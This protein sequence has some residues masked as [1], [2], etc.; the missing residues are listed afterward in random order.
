MI[1]ELYLKGRLRHGLSQEEAEAI[2]DAIDHVITLE[3]REKLVTRGEKVEQSYYIIDGSMMRCIDDA[4]GFRQIVGLQVPGDW[5][6][7]HSFPMKRLD[8]DVHALA[9]SRLAVFRHERLQKLID[10]RPHLARIMWF[11]TLLDAAMHREWIFRLGR[12]NAEGRIAHLI[13]ELLE[14]L[15]LVGRLEESSFPFPLTQQDFAEA[16]GITTT[17]ANRTF[18]L[19]RERGLLDH[20][21][22]TREMTIID[23]Q[24]LR[25]LGEF[26]P[27]YL[28][29]EGA[30][31]LNTAFA[32]KP[33]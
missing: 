13:C 14:R 17:H 16:S 33:A 8:H 2:D 26:K 23:E 31:H 3:P 15:R 21:E 10:D 24:S 9:A 19:L 25:E 6:D 30:L 12:L 28:Y 22:N 20:D 18:R 5:V 29:G 32:D 7:L 27:D 4:R 1:T 11:S